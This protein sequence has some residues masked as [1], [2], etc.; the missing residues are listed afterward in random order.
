M[1]EKPRSRCHSLIWALVKSSPSG[2]EVQCNII[3]SIFLLLESIQLLQLCARSTHDCCTAL[4]VRQWQ[5]N[6][7]LAEVHK[8]AVIQWV[9]LGIAVVEVC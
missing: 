7:P 3:W 8:V 1:S 9:V 6:A 4:G 5:T 2:V